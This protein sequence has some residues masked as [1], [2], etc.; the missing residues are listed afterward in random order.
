MKDSLLTLHFRKPGMYTVLQDL[1]RTE[2]SASGVPAGGASDRASAMAANQ[3]AGNPPGHPVL[4]I[5]MTGP[6]IH[7]DKPCRI[8]ITGADMQPRIDGVECAM[9]STVFLQGDSLLTFGKLRS[10][11]RAYLAV[12]GTWQVD[13]WLGS[14]S[15]LPYADAASVSARVI[16]DGSEIRV[17]VSSGNF[18]QISL[19]IPEWPISKKVRVLPGPEFKKFKAAQ[20]ASFFNTDFAVSPES[21]RI[22]YRL[23]PPLD[24]YT[25]VAELP[26]SGMIPGVVQV[27]RQG[28]FVVLL[29]DAQTTG[30]YP[31]IAV[32]LDADLDALAQLKPG[33]TVS[34]QIVR[35]DAA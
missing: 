21:N 33:D 11:C 30:G 26:S 28:Q 6:E 27:T 12:G 24:D 15:V 22:G 32:V 35:G 34:F 20:I 1:G 17:G 29:A 4:E 19:P 7:F 31:R 5:T 3:C 8:A 2:G 25:P 23:H 10:G 9:Y 16:Q 14:V 13:H 18:D